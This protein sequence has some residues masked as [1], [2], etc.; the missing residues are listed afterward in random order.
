MTLPAPPVAVVK[1]AVETRHGHTREDP[2]GW[3]KDTDWQ[4]V[5]KTPEV[6]DGEIRA[7]LEA[8]NA[9]T[10]AAL[11]STET[12]QRRLIAEMRGRIK[13]DDSS[14]PAPDGPFAYYVRYAAGGQHPMFCRGA[15][16]GGEETV[17]LDGDREAEGQSFFRVAGCEHSPDHRLLAYAVD[18]NG[19]EYHTVRLRDLKTGRDLPDRMEQT[20]GDL[21]WANDG[22]TVYYTVFDDNHRPR[23]VRRHRVGEAPEADTLVYEESDHGFYLGIGRTESQRLITIGAHDHETDEVH[24]ADADDPAAPLRLVAPRD[25]GVKYTVSHHGDRLIILT[26][27]DG[28]EDFKVVEAP[29]ADPGR[30]RWRDLVPHEPGR[31]IRRILVFRDHLARLETVAALPRIVIRRLADGAEHV[32]DFDEE[33]YDLGLQPGLEFDTTVLRFVY[34]SP[35]TPRRTYDYDMEAR[36]RTLRKEQEVPSGHDPSRYVTRRLFVAAPDGARVPITVLHR[37]ETPMDGSAPLFLYGYGAYGI[38]M[39]ASFRTERLS[40][41]D[42]GF[43]H[44]V[45]HIRGGM[46]GG[47]NWYRDGK[48]EKKTNTFG[49]FIACAEFLVGEG[50]GRAGE[51]AAHGGSAGGMLMGAVTNMRPD[52]FKAIVAEVPF[53]DVLNTMCD[54][55]LP[56]TPPEWPE[57]GNPIEDAEAY[58]RILSYSPYDN[59]APQA[60]PNILATGGLTDPRV[61]YWEPA[62]WVARLRTLNTSDSLILLKIN[63]EAG[64]AGAAG[65]FDKLEEVA[66]AYAF[67]LKVFGREDTPPASA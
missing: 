13:E 48:R 47:F 29:L 37:A 16:D 50:Y 40:L 24:V 42:R 46:E 18:L 19:S 20:Q 14:V 65:R 59:V 36:Q 30:S 3:L 27:A 51:I 57:W 61:T 22:A 17:L 6:L 31:L 34:S 55:N 25:P 32:V 21:E 54:A 43:I 10:Q 45:A 60:Y 2:Y 12:L 1:P 64:H 5:I 7:Y 41:V 52:L 4:Q 56:L 15:R 35:T 28:A 58:R 53:V 11:A 26:N 8:E 66:R 23:W 63:M 49:D 39:P 44:A 67:T 33:A 9:F 38:S 62:K